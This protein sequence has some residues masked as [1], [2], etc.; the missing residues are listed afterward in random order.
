MRL[1]LFL[2]PFICAALPAS[3]APPATPSA[4]LQKE[5]DRAMAAHPGTFVIVDVFT[6]GVLASHNLQI[7][8]SHLE[9]PGSTLKPFVLM[10]LLESGKLDPKQKIVCRRPLR[11]G[12]VR[13]DCTHPVQIAE[14]DAADAI[15]YSCNS[16]VSQVAARLSN[17]ELVE[18]LR[19][20]GFDSPTKLA[21]H[22]ASG[23]ITLPSSLEDLQLEALGYRGIEVTPLELLQ[24]YRK[25]AIRKRDG[26]LGADTPVFLGLEHSVAFGM[27]HAA[28]VEGMTMA[29][30][31]G[32][33]PARNARY[34][35]GF[36]A[37]Y[38]PAEKPEVAFVVFLQQ[39]RGADA[40]AVGQPV[41]EAYAKHRNAN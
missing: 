12:D 33:A 31:T 30:K 36:F 29:G 18:L 41:F 9:S 5:V 17:S 1:A 34:T 11:M 6:G 37:G 20:A 2:A 19:H 10:A 4:Y 3:Q 32:T 27:A 7:A 40:A 24:A 15:A 35:H 13:M 39:G 28:N 38:A 23:R 16:Y 21:A 8:S 26:E 22:E 25:L 14:L